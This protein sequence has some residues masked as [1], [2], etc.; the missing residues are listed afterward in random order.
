M[1]LAS[2]SCNKGGDIPNDETSPPQTNYSINFFNPPNSYDVLENKLFTINIQPQLNAE[3]GY[4]KMYFEIVH[5]GTVLGRSNFVY[6]DENTP[7]IKTL[8]WGGGEGIYFGTNFNYG[9]CDIVAYLE[10]YDLFP[11]RNKARESWTRQYGS[12][13][14][15]IYHFNDNSIPFANNFDV[16]IDYQENRNIRNH[17]DFSSIEGA[18]DPCLVRFYFLNEEAYGTDENLA[19]ELIIYS[20]IEILSV[21]DTLKDVSSN[22]YV[23]SIMGFKD[24][25]NNE[26]NNVAGATISRRVL[27]THFGSFIAFNS[28][29]AAFPPNKGEDLFYIQLI[30]STLIH[31]I[32]HQV[33]LSD[34][35]HTNHDGNNF[36]VMYQGTYASFDP[37][38]QNLYGRSFYLNPHFC[39]KHVQEINQ[40]LHQ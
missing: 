26:L 6:F 38:S 39:L 8:E 20:P 33:W 31:E 9:D 30:N 34:D 14:V 27:S 2:Q 5:S 17:L 36:C 22:Y 13:Q 16:E 23:Y 4:F 11:N 3:T 24:E 7:G 19:P 37:Q 18:F 29:F 21:I 32:G 10:K 1:V 15:R 35:S 25:N 28:I 12:N 40:H